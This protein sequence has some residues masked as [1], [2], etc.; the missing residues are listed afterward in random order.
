MH[1]NWQVYA[2]IENARARDLNDIDSFTINSFQYKASC[3]KQLSKICVPSKNMQFSIDH[4]Y[5]DFRGCSF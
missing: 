4:L 1:N 2:L 5:A 3:H